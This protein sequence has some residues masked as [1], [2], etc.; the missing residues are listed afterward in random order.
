[1]LI[2]DTI[3][4][5][6]LR[7]IDRPPLTTHHVDGA[8]PAG[9]WHE[10]ADGRLVCD[11]CPRN[12]SLKPG[13][14]GFCFVREN[15]DGEMLLTT[16][17]K[18]TGFCIDPIEKKPLNHFYP[19]TSVLSFGT[20]GCNLGCKFC[21][22][23]DI[24]KAREV[25][26]LSE[27]AM[28]DAIA[29]AAVEQ[30]CRSVAFTYNDP[31]VWA[32]YAI[33]T[34]KAC[35]AVDVKTVAVTAGYI[36]PN[37]RE[38]FFEYFDAANVDLKAFTEDFYE[39]VTLS[40]LQPVLD[41]LEW[42]QRET[43]VW[44]EITNLLIPGANDS[45]DELR[46]L[47]DWVLTHVGDQVPVHFSAFHPDF[48][49]LDRGRTPHE[50]LLEAYRIAEA[51]GLKYV[52]VGNVNDTQHQSTWC[53]SCGRRLIERNWYELGEY[54]LD[55]NRC[56]YCGDEVPGQFDQQRGNWGRKRKPIQI[57]QYDDAGQSPG[58]QQRPNGVV[59]MQ[60]E[61]GD[62]EQQSEEAPS[63]EAPIEEATTKEDGQGA[64]DT[65]TQDAATAKQQRPG[66]FSA[67][68]EQAI[69]KVTADLVA[70]AV[71]EEA[72]TATS[73]SLAGAADFMVDGVY[74][75]LKRNGHLR[76]CCG[77]TGS[78]VPLW[79]GLQFAAERTAIEDTRMP[80]VSTSELPY[81]D[82]EV[83][84]LGGLMPVNVTGPDRVQEI[85][86]GRDGLLI[87]RGNQ[88][89][90]LLPGVAVDNGWDETN[91]LRQICIKAQLPPTAWREPDT[92]LQRFE[93][94]VVKGP[95]PAVREQA[96]VSIL[97]NNAIDA[98]AEFSRGN[99]RAFAARRLPNYYVTA[100]E[101][102]NV[103]GVIVTASNEEGRRLNAAKVATRRTM[104]LQST[105]FELSQ[106]IAETI[107][108][109]GLDANRFQ[110]DVAVLEDPAMHGT[111]RQPDTRGIDSKRGLFAMGPNQ[112][113][114]FH[115]QAKDGD[116]SQLDELSS[117][118]DMRPDQ[119]ASLLSFHC[120]ASA[121]MSAANRIHPQPG[122]P[123][124]PPAVAGKF[125]PATANGL[126][127]AVRA[128][129]PDQSAF[130]KA[131]WRAAMLP[132]AG[133]KYSG[134]VAA[135]VLACLEI[136]ERVIVIGPK[137][138][139]LGV[140]WAVAPHRSW[141]LPGMTMAGDPELAQMLAENIEHLELD[142]AAHQTEHAIEIELPLLHHYAPEAKV[143]GIAIGSGDL[144]ACRQFAH[145]LTKVIAMMEDD[146]LILISSDMNHF[147]S[148]GET[149]RL[150]AIAIDA[151]K[152][153]DPK[154]A[155]KTV[156]ENQIS[157][158]GLL[159]AV[160][161]LEALNE[162]RPLTRVE[163]VAY[164]TS[165]EVTGDSSRVVGYAGLLVG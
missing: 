88:R 132:H 90:L 25:S 148:D 145:G 111:T 24:S 12:C 91:F 107:V 11:L 117:L 118:L 119:Q 74:V 165:A 97:P 131:R 27:Y 48:R 13:D 18:S 40:H 60:K 17:G 103:N 147:A 7:T 96:F 56:E 108:R 16:Y 58:Q 133:L 5:D 73:A 79:R 155:F 110:I 10:T 149:R 92:V 38:P 98:L 30:G 100:V 82:V 120:N 124:R 47:C 75:S 81:L 150:D 162:V 19:G 42:L 36:S 2:R 157:M 64:T 35:R 153:L 59:A 125:Y 142:V 101:D 159:P 93:G 136:P 141:A 22:N 95:L 146:L 128:L 115:Y 160:I 104:P 1:M 6:S 55:G 144:N 89:G 41:T 102:G 121:D 123:E 29:R 137:H 86:V 138:T 34:A 46:Q 21:Q 139:R 15:R 69:L 113:W 77:F 68:Q 61:S 54:R 164:A 151:I 140:D 62:A 51:A 37:A 85:K 112:S 80:P 20:A 63:K 14:R 152:G 32:E 161:V 154:H 126:A 156:R 67:S 129:I 52:Y 76:G 26:R 135:E 57:S 53:K 43:D 94:L 99:I 134:R 70:A 9:W 78:T 39:S 65:A 23:H 143:T 114:A 28:P 4:M 3:D 71:R 127:A 44:F 72:V 87:Q 50:K 8:T 66:P 106:E 116:Q 130:P 31:I 105:L 109:L 45:A 122:D 163:Q 84:L 49:M 158:C 83:W 33:D